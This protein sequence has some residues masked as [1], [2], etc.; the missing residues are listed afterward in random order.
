MFEDNDPD[1]ARS[2]ANFVL[3]ARAW[4]GGFR[5]SGYKVHC[6]Q[7]EAIEKLVKLLRLPIERLMR[8]KWRYVDLDAASITVWPSQF[9]GPVTRT[10]SHAALVVLS[11]FEDNGSEY[12]FPRYGQRPPK[13]SS[14]PRLSRPLPKAVKLAAFKFDEKA[15]RHLRGL[16]EGYD[17]AFL[18]EEW[19][20]F[21]SEAGFT[22]YETDVLPLKMYSPKTS[23]EEW[24][25][26]FLKTERAH[27]VVVC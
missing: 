1:L 26:D 4:R 12:V 3:D 14:A 19:R 10:L 25:A 21:V 8:L 11:E 16:A 7:L 15:M 9:E 17:L 18:E 5:K 20:A 2:F 22:L 27:G 6:S 24:L 23:F 13:I